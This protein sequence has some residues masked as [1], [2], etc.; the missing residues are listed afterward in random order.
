M[1]LG[2]TSRSSPLRV[3]L[4]YHLFA[5]VAEEMGVV[6][7]NSAFSPNIKERRDFSCALFNREGGLL[8]QAAHIP[9]HLGSM[10]L[11][12]KS[13]LQRLSFQEGDIVLVN[14]PYAGGTHLPDITAVTALFAGKRPSF[15]L[16]CRAHHADVGGKVSGSMPQARR[17]EEEGVVI[18]PTKWFA[19]GR[20]DRRFIRSF[21]AQVRNPDE[22]RGD[23]QAQLAACRAGEARLQ[24][25]I[26]RYGLQRIELEGEELIRYS[27]RLM[28]ALVARFPNGCWEAE[29]FLDDDGLGGSPVRIHVAMEKRQ[30]RLCFDFRGSASQ[31]AGPLNAVYPVLLSSVFYVLR[32]LSQVELPENEGVIQAVKVKAT[33][34]TVV[35]AQYPAAVSSGNVETSQ[36]IVDV[37][38]RVMAKALPQRIPAASQGTMNNLAFGGWDPFRKKPFTFYETI[39]GGAGAG[40]GWDGA[41]AV[42]CHMTNTLNTPIEAMEQELPVRVSRYRIR[43]KSGGRGAYRGGDGVERALAFLVPA[44][45]TFIAERRR[46]SPYGLAGGEDGKQGGQYLVRGG[47]RLRLPGKTTFRA[48]PGDELVILTPG[49]GGWGQ[50]ESAAFRANVEKKGRPKEP[51]LREF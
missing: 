47:Q 5:S 23:L 35:C 18:P 13:C 48:E 46:F 43:R 17:L 29:D 44:E 14:D 38:Y 41:S 2:K 31:V 49:G 10:S 30:G 37:L 40:P 26:S 1:P 25:L 45:V 24:G 27:Q 22:R 15:Y 32:T 7:Q 11:A 34:G 42:Q 33:P 3:Q 36:R 50:H 20:E 19:A 51:T 9:V 12:V 8:S 6:L 28:R 39:A 21:M 16:A 4:F